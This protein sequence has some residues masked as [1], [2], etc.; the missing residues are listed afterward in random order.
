[1]N[2]LV[3][4]ISSLRLDVVDSAGKNPEESDKFVCN[5]EQEYPDIIAQKQKSQKRDAWGKEIE[6]LLS[7]IAMSVGLGMLE[8]A[9]ISINF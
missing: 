7:C 9:G 5:F 3:K 1:M 2:D 8:A 4:T 6:F